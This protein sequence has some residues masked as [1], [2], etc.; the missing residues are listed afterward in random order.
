[1][2]I[3]HRDL[4]PANIFL[5]SDKVLKIGDFGIAKG[6]DK[7]S[8]L[9]S[10]QAGTPVYMAPEILGGDKYNSMADMWALGIT[11]FE[12]ITYKKPF[13]GHD[14]LQAISKE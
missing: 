6:L 11:I 7:T 1:M 2:N 3:I 12:I 5:T 10:T 4:K 14:W 13:H 9:A 8:A